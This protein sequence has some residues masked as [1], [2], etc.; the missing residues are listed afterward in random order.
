MN[1]KFHNGVITQLLGCMDEVVRGEVIVIGATN[2]LEAIDPAFRRPGRFDK[3][4]C[5][6][7]PNAAARTRILKIHSRRWLNQ[8]PSHDYEAVGSA[9]VGYSGA[10]L[11]Q[12]C[13]D[14]FGTAFHRQFP[15]FEE[16]G[17]LDLSSLQVKIIIVW[18]FA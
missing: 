18:I 9:T 6:H 13:R 10:D 16:S 17:P 3:S 2:R 8:P 11:E 7:L 4:I 5:F 1:N 15:D 12:L 14:T